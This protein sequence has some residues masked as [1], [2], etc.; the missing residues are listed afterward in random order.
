VPVLLDVINVKGEK[1]GKVS[2]NPE[3]FEGKISPQAVYEDIRR[4]LASRREGTAAT[5][6]RSDVR[7]GGRRPWRQKGTGRARAGSIRSPLWR[8]GGD[9]FGPH[10]RDYSFSIPKKVMKLALKSVLLD[11]LNS[12]CLII[13]DELKIGHP[14]TKEVAA[15]LNKLKLKEKKVIFLLDGRNEIFYRAA[16]NL[17][18]VSCKE[19]KAVNTFD[20]LYNDRLVFTKGAFDSLEKRLFYFSKASKDKPPPVKKN[21]D[22]YL[23]GNK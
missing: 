9:I 22:H 5:K 1:V 8:G 15:I 17:R 16:R 11:K 23:K 20:L 7:G 21:E 13:I 6:G 12:N 3:I 19:V 4:L 18:G 10:P 14:K 2:L